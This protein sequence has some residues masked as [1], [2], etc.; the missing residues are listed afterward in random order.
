MARREGCYDEDE[1]QNR[2]SF[3]EF[4]NVE[5]TAGS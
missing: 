5:N 4:K 2:I 1:D 3:K